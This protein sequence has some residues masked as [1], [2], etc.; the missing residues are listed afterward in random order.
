[1]GGRIILGGVRFYAN[2]RKC[3]ITFKRYVAVDRPE[4]SHLRE[5]IS[6]P[7]PRR[8]CVPLVNILLRILSGEVDVVV[9]LSQMVRACLAGMSVWDI[10]TT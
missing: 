5:N 1:M 7:V 3:F 8:A 2:N 4:P 6:V 9:R 10:K